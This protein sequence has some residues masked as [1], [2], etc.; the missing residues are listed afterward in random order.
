[1]LRILLAYDRASV[2]CQTDLHNTVLLDS[3][4]D[5]FWRW[6]ANARALIGIAI[7][8]RLLFSGI[9]PAHHRAIGH[10]GRSQG[11]AQAAP[12][13]ASHKRAYRKLRSCKWHYALLLPRLLQWH[14]R[15]QQGITEKQGDIVVPHTN[16]YWDACWRRW[17]RAIDIGYPNLFSNENRVAM[18]T[19]LSKLCNKLWGWI[20]FARFSGEITIDKSTPK[21][22]QQFEC[23]GCATSPLRKMVPEMLP[24]KAVDALSVYLMPLIQSKILWSL[25]LLLAQ[26]VCEAHAV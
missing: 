19:V 6:H 26:A 4:A 25:R 8:N 11:A 21:L 2:C 24:K 22:H 10:I 14:G 17:S 7:V 18:W 9:A 23:Q 3:K 16:W 13:K 15:S 20:E 1:M 12:S 5:F